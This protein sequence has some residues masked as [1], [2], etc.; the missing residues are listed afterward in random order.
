MTFRSLSLKFPSGVKAFGSDL[1]SEKV[2]RLMEIWRS[3]IE[4]I[5]FYLILAATR[6]AE[7]KGISAAG[8]TPVSRRYTAVADTELLLGGPLSPRKWQLPPLP[9]GV[10]PA[11]ISY[12][13]SQFIGIKPIVIPIG[14]SQSLSFPHL[15]I[16]P[17]SYGAADCV[18]T[19]KSMSFDRVENLWNRGFSMGMRMEGPVLIAECVPGGTTTAYAVLSGLGLKFKCLET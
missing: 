1:S 15:L 6:T 13:S 16:E 8:S 12:V 19:G 17:P 7:V 10:T 5:S 9:G 14:L 18:S 11:L 4:K 2:N 3:S